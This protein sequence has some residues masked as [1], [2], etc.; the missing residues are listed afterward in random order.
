MR[1]CVVSICIEKTKQLLSEQL[2]LVRDNNAKTVLNKEKNS[3]DN[4]KAT[5]QYCHLFSFPCIILKFKKN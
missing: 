5:K 2:L 1:K 4:K 3:P